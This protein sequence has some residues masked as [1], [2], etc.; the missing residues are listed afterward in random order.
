[1][2]V[3]K[4]LIGLTLSWL[5]GNGV[6]VAADANVDINGDPNVDKGLKADQASGVPTALSTWI[7]LAEQGNA[8]AQSNLGLMYE[9]GNGVA[10]NYNTAVNWYTLAAKQGDVVAQFNLGSMYDAGK[11]VLENDTTAVKWLNLA[12]G[13]GYVR[14]QS[15]LG[16]MYVNGEGVQADYLRAYMWWS[17]SA[18]NG[19]NLAAGY[20]DSIANKMMPAHISKAQEM[21]NRCLDSDYIDC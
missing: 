5:L 1:M 7:V 3:K 17:I 6:V 9:H 20:K 15:Y 2:D 19:D 8:S 4:L 10:R 21:V 14:A 11:G 16:V 18:R 12:A 13:Q